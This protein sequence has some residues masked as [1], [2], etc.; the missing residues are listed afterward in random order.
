MVSVAFIFGAISVVSIFALLSFSG[1]GDPAVSPGTVTSI[2]ASEANAL[3]SNYLKTADT[4]HKP[5]KGFFLDEQ[6]LEAL[7]MVAGKNPTLAGFR[8]Y[9]GKDPK[10]MLVGMVVAVDDKNADLI[11]NGIYKTGSVKTGPCPVI[12][13]MESPISGND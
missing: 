1:M 6:E 4:I 13:D 5:L 10:G 7:N 12:C 8:I 11:S 2:T 9:F 3:L